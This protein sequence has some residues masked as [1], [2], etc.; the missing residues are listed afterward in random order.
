MSR[1][2]RENRESRKNREKNGENR[3]N[4]ENSKSSK[5]SKNKERKAHVNRMLRRIL[6][7]L[8]IIFAGL[9]IVRLR[10]TG[11]DAQGETEATQAEST[12]NAGETGEAGETGNAETTAVELFG[13]SL[14]SNKFQELA[15]DEDVVF[16][17]MSSYYN[18]KSNAEKAYSN[19]H[20][21]SQAGVTDGSYFV[22]AAYEVSLEG[23]DTPVPSLSW[24]YLQTD[25]D[26]SLQFSD[27]S[28]DELAL[29]LI[30]SVRSS[31]EGQTLINLAQQAYE[32]AV[33]SDAALAQ[34]MQ[35]YRETEAQQEAEAV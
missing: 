22:Y 31:E 3:K 1:E 8:I 19:L 30:E 7:L 5:N 34:Y 14:D 15:Q 29:Q 12:G 16:A 33:E 2:S 27:A 28:E 6:I 35:M 13:K 26:G 10:S 23:I 17:V 21:W 25:E 20:T 11:K 18:E 24:A 4:R 9:L 32:E